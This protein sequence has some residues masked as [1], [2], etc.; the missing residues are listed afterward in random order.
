MTTYHKLYT[1]FIWFILISVIAVFGLSVFRHSFNFPFYDDFENIVLFI[2]KFIAAKNSTS[3]L[4][5]LFEQNFEHRVLFSKLVTLAQ[6]LITG[7]VNVK[8]LI[9]I[10]DL[11]L[12]GILWLFYTYLKAARLSLP[13]LLAVGCLLFQ[14]Q[15]YEDTISWATCSLQHAPCIFFSLWSFHLALHRRSLF[16][17][18]G[19]ALLALFTS[20]NGLVTVG[21]WLLIVLLVTDKKWKIAIPAVILIAITVV[22]LATLTIHSGSV[23]THVTSHVGPKFVLLLSFVGQLADPNLV[24]RYLSVILGILFVLP[25]PLAAFQVLAGRARSVSI[26]QWLCVAGIC[27]LLFVAFL[28]LFARGTEPDPGG[29]KM[30]R[31]KIYAAFFGAF[32]LAFY[33]GYLNASFTAGFLRNVAAGLCILFV[34]GSHYIYYVPLVNYQSAIEANQFNFFWSERIQYP[35][36]FDDRNTRDYLRPAQASFLRN[37]VPKADHPLLTADWKSVKDTIITEKVEEA[38][39]IRLQQDDFQEVA[40]N[41]QLFV[42][43][44]RKLERTPGY[45]FKVEKNYPSG[46]RHFFTEFSRPAGPGFNCIV[47]KNKMKQGEYEILLVSLKKGRPA[48]LYY[49]TQITI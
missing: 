7:Q 24:P 27:S 2:H 25:L 3:K 37:S 43:A 31:Y 15:S 30:D 42:V 11:S 33:D 38:T 45:L 14:L 4:A 13:A 23:L 17:S 44:V 41:D 32:A 46:L 8:W 40:G 35:L 9:I 21:I 6:Y 1:L 36:I 47:Y 5:L 18:G 48:H 28:I 49:L 26:L 34:I 12:L 22:H 19:L 29:Y 20:A 10:G 39:L 16:A